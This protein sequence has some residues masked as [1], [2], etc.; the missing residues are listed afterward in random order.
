MY[1]MFDGAERRRL[2]GGTCA[3]LADWITPCHL[4]SYY[5]LLP[6]CD[7]T[8]LATGVFIKQLLYNIH[9]ALHTTPNPFADPSLMSNPD[10]QSDIKV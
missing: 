1:E 6:P 5:I 3:M 8:G 10:D 9:Q 2:T 7:G 4:L